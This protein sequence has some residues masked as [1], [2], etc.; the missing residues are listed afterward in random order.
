MQQPIRSNR[1]VLRSP[2]WAALAVV[3]ASIAFLPRA[4]PGADPVSPD[5]KAR[6]QP[7]LDN[8]CYDCHGDGAKKGKVSLDEF[9]S[10]EAMLHDRELWFKVLKNV[11]ARVMPP[12]TE[13]QQPTDAERTDLENWIKRDVLK[14]D[15]ANPDPGR[16]TLRRLNRVE[17]RNTIAD[18]MGVDFRAEEE[19]PPD[20]TGYG[21]DNIG[22]VLTVS[23]LLLEKYM[24]A[25]ESVVSKSVPVEAKVIREFTIA[26]AKFR[27]DTDGDGTADANR[28]PDDNDDDPRGGRGDVRNLSFYKPAKIAYA[29]KVEQAGTY[30]LVVELNV[31]GEFDFDPGK[32]RFTF[33]LDDK[34]LMNQEFAWQN[35]KT[36]KHEFEVKWEPGE[37]KMA[38]ELEPLTPLE[39]KKNSIDMRVMAVHVVG[40]LEPELWVRPKNFE[41]FFT[42]DIPTDDAGKREYAREILARFTRKAYRRPADSRTLDRLVAIAE[43]GYK[44]PGKSFQ[45]G[46]RGAMVA[47]LA[48]PRFVFRQ[49]EPDAASAA[50]PAPHPLVDEFALAARL[51]YFLWSTTPDDELSSLAD[52]GEL[53]KNLPAQVKRMLASPRSKQFVQN[54]VGQWLQVRD[55]DGI[56]I[57]ERSVLARDSGEDRQFQR[58]QDERRALIAKIE[59]LPE[60][61]RA[62]EFEKIRAQ[63][64]NRRRFR[65]PAVELN[66]G[67]RRPMR[68]ESE[69]LFEHVLRED[70]TVL[71]FL[72]SDYTFLN[73]RLAKHYGI[74]G[75][76]GDEMRRVDL[77]KDSPRGGVLTQGAVLVVTSNP[78]RTS[79]VKRGLFVLEN[80]LGSPTPPPPADVPDLEDS[81]KGITDHEPTTRE[82]LAIHREKTLCAS[83]HNRMDPL[84]LA[85]ESFNA[86]GMFR[87]SERKQPLDVA[88]RLITGESFNGIKELKKI[89]ATS[90]KNDFYQ[91]LT[92]KVMTYALGRGLDYYD[93]ES[94]DQVVAKLNKE[95]GRFSALITGIVESAPF[96]KTRRP[97]PPT[98]EP[99]QQAKAAD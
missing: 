37:K 32:C 1:A 87:E 75:V 54:F 2:V 60:A 3:V 48:S 51:S 66:D 95:D 47:V 30:K 6:I 20:D 76:K 78:T 49:E 92:E 7:L 15:P 56:S 70:R 36:S 26:G 90:R 89:L 33:K 16:V 29:H 24:E 17:Y 45:E 28:K 42:R 85:L 88:G 8:F 46:M 96:Q 61:E 35:G 71:D 43:Q 11:R 73:E 80:I 41:R 98:P 18:L 62:K 53:R 10:E 9:A 83:C 91:C 34:E 31:R 63:F 23:P 38:F 59:A 72:D 64:R 94:V 57:N 84:G 74:R 86:L 79:P 82:I 22:D 19:F 77:P 52:K 40:P 13:E 12:A 67:L 68:R 65:P 50:S 81:E 99:A 69:M 4:S 21:F 5:F 58:Q 39:Q 44:E 25:A 93:V 14:I 27:R 55:V 97:T